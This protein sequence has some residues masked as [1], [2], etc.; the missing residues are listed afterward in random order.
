MIEESS[1]IFLPKLIFLQFLV[2][3]LNFCVNHKMHLSWKWCETG[4][5]STKILTHRVY[6][7]ICHLSWKR[8]KTQQF[9]QNFRGEGYTQ[10]YANFYQ[11][12]FHAI[13][14]D[15]LKFLLK[16][17]ETLFILERVQERGISM[18]FQTGYRKSSTAF[19]QKSFSCHIWQSS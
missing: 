12:F 7:V 18:K 2:P 1:V 5:I 19:Y 11:K 14:G 4:A 16:M 15:H 17:Q 13:F 9:Q 10:S 6:A 3:I 8:R